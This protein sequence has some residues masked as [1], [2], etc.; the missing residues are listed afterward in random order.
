MCTS[1]ASIEIPN[2]VTY[3]DN[4]AFSGCSSLT[5]IEIPNSVTRLGGSVFADCDALISVTI[6]SSL[7]YMQDYVFSN[8]NSLTSIYYN[9]EEPIKANS[10]VFQCADD[11]I[12]ENATL[13]VPEA[14]VEKCRAI[15]PWSM[16]KNI[17]A[18]DFSAAV[19]FPIEIEINGIN[20]RLEAD[21]TA[22]LNEK[23]N[24]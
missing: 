9:V 14:T 4:A 10:N 17:S 19:E 3:I 18:H 5:S 15:E 24:G 12:Y 23:K 1:L 13:Y 16:F 20:Y 22:V 8:C 21:N 2:S 7:S 6:P 11:A